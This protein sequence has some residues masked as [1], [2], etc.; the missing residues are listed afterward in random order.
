MAHNSQ[1]GEL[2]TPHY[3]L[4]VQID[5][6]RGQAHWNVAITFKSKLRTAFMKATSFFGKDS[7]LFVSWRGN[8]GEVSSTLISDEIDPDSLSASSTT[9][10]VRVHALEVTSKEDYPTP[11]K[12]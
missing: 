9:V 8:G 3:C 1:S 4:P 10:V 11:L 7:V 12:L 6:L 2:R 5:Y